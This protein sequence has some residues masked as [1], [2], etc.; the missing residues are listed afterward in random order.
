LQ[1]IFNI[2][3]NSFIDNNVGIAEGF[4]NESL[5]THLKENLLRLFA[6]KQM[7][8]AG[9]GNDTLVVHDKLMRNDKIYWLDRNHNNIYENDFF[10]LMDN[11]VKHLNSTCYTGITGYEFHY[12]LYETGSF[13]KRHLDQF[14]NNDSRKYTMILYLNEGWKENDG[15]QLRIYHTGSEQNISP[16]N[17]KSVFF[18]SSELEHEVLVTN[19]PRMSITGWLKVN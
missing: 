11:F 8:S 2:L 9:T 17:G 4:L 1:N 14:R 6:E 19:K 16:V 5:A 7:L 10:D 13:Y 15:G 3:I 12:A 18:K